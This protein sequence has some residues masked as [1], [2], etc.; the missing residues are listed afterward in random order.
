MHLKFTLLGWLLH[1]SLAAFA[2]SAL[3]FG[4]RKA[5]GARRALMLGSLFAAAAVGRRAWI[6]GHTP[7]Q[8][9][10]E[11]FIVMGALVY[12]LSTFCR[13]TLPRSGEGMDA[14]LG[15]LVLFPAA[16]VFSEAPRRLP[17]ALQ[18]PLF[19][20]HVLTYLAAYV[21]LAKAALLSMLEFT[22]GDAGGKADASR[23]AHRLVGW[24]F[25]LLT[26]GLLL[27]SWWGKLAWGDYWH[28]DPK[29]MWSLATWLIYVGYYHARWM[30]GRSQPRLTA[31]L[32]VS[33]FIAIILTVS[34]VNLS[35]IFSG[36]H[37]YAQ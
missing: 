26:A 33:G 36:M 12:P 18:S 9:L 28:W 22:A 5:G 11:I 24:G 7:M 2:V 16:F 14:W 37:S 15:I 17:P 29:E 34:W 27:G 20:P 30:F 10:F 6:T 25:P 31:G 13:R 23:S 4:I 3:L 35:R 19:I 21:A 32:L 8:N 1:A